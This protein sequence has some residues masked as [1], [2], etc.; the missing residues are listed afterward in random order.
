VPPHARR[1]FFA[2]TAAGVGS[3]AVYGVFN[4][5]A[6][7]FLAG[8]L[9]E[10]SHAVAGAVAFAAF[11][12]G[13]LAQVALSR[14]SVRET[15]RI[16]PYLLIPG[17]A[18]LVAGMWLPSLAVFVIGGVVT[19]AGG[20]LVFRGALA[21]AGSTAPPGARAEVLAGYFLGAYV[22]LS[23]P[24]VALGVATHYVAARDA[25]LVFVVLVS[26]AVIVSVRAVMREQ[27]ID[28]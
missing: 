6:P 10:T 4:S 9:H 11:A 15:L 26:I 7:S 1:A 21:A 18:L 24:V 3:F 5:L 16:S 17:L 20:G 14:V 27:R 8:T 19:G 22:G 25:V 12:S 28:A 2:A 13:A 23:V